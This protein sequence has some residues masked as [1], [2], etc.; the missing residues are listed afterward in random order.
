MYIVDHN[1]VF[2]I[3]NTSFWNW[4]YAQVLGCTHLAVWSPFYTPDI[5]GTAHGM[6]IV[7]RCIFVFTKL[8]FI[9]KVYILNIWTKLLN[10]NAHIW[11]QNVMFCAHILF[12]LWNAINPHQNMMRPIMFNR[13]KKC[14]VNIKYEFHR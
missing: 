5:E 2:V 14:F 8:T 11:I 3:S 10:Y 7:V 4:I 6:I 12:T 1:W 13:K 9:K